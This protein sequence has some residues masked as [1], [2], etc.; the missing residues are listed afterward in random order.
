MAHFLF[1]DFYVEMQPPPRTCGYHYCSTDRLLMKQLV[2]AKTASEGDPN[3]FETAFER[4]D[5]H[6]LKLESLCS[7]VGETTFALAVQSFYSML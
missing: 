3:P 5:S 2:G 7:A 1:F 6:C 4:M